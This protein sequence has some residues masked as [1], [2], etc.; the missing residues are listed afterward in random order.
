MECRKM[1]SLNQHAGFSGCAGLYTA[2]VF[3]GLSARRNIFFNS[4]L[5]FT[6]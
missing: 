6:L 1:V 3:E 4:K 2:L 5:L